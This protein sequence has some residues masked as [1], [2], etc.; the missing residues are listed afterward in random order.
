MK[1][2]DRAL[3]KDR[4]RKYKYYRKLF[5][6]RDGAS[7][8]VDVSMKVKHIEHTLRYEFLKCA[9]AV[10]IAKRLIDIKG[11]LINDRPPPPPLQVKPRK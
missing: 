2:L 6:A 8:Y 3:K 4:Q 9:D 11:D 7:R 1:A 5:Q 10:A